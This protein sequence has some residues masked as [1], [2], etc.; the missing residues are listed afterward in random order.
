MGW[1]F[2]ALARAVSHPGSARRHD[3]NRAGGPR[4]SAVRSDALASA[5]S[6]S[7]RWSLAAQRS[8]TDGTTALFVRD[9]SDATALPRIA[10]VQVEFDIGKAASTPQKVP[11]FQQVFRKTRVTQPPQRSEATLLIRQTSHQT[12]LPT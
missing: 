7:L 3:E 1:P 6:G 10:N 5:L 11:M 2:N 12:I 8:A 9:G 4:Y